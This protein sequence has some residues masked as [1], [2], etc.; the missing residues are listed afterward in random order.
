MKLKVHPSRL[1]RWWKS[2]RTNSVNQRVIKPRTTGGCPQ[3]TTLL[4]T[5]QR[6]TSSKII[7]TAKKLYRTPALW[8]DQSWNDITIFEFYDSLRAVN[9][10]FPVIRDT[11][12]T[13]SIVHHPPCP[14]HPRNIPNNTT[15][16]VLCAFHH[17]LLCHS[18][19]LVWETLQKFLDRPLRVGLLRARRASSRENKRFVAIWWRQKKPQR[20]IRSDLLF[21][22]FL[23]ETG[24]MIRFPA[25]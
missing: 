9:T 19:Q 15:L 1:L 11:K 10:V 18:D 23:D 14:A 6:N 21:E 17:R 3:Y 5:T 22:L 20:S 24:L 8:T 16:R 4:Y 12:V 25:A 13:K 7:D 2:S